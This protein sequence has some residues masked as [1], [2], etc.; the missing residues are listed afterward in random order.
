MNAKQIFIDDH[1]RT[2]AEWNGKTATKPKGKAT[3]GK[4][5]A[6]SA[7]D[8]EQSVT[9]DSTVAATEAATVANPGG[10]VDVEDFRRR[11]YRDA[12][13][14]SYYDLDNFFFAL[15]H[16]FRDDNAAGRT[17]LRVVGLVDFQHTSPLGDEHAHKLF[18]L[19]KV[20]RTDESRRR[21]DYPKCGDDSNDSDALKSNYCGEAPEGS[22][23]EV[24]NK[25]QKQVRVTARRLVWEIPAASV[26][27]IR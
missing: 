5:V 26:A 23:R 15:M 16:M 20:R 25:G 6:V 24:E 8:T 3:K 27:D 19:V 11:A 18:E 17:G 22:V 2:E 10:T 7:S 9:I 1:H 12:L 14:R 13:C 21:G 4:E